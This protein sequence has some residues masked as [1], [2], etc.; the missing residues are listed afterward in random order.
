[1]LR[2]LNSTALPDG[3]CSAMSCQSTGATV[4]FVRELW[5]NN[6]SRCEILGWD[7]INKPSRRRSIRPCSANPERDAEVLAIQAEAKL[8]R[9]KQHNL[10]SEQPQWS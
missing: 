10:T 7:V 3:N 1:M 5:W 6:T 4:A 8:T 2:I 9:H